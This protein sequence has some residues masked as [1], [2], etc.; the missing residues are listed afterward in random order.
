MNSVKT[1]LL[2]FFLL[3]GGALLGKYSSSFLSAEHLRGVE[4][5]VGLLTS[6]FGLLLSLQLSAGKTYFDHQEQD[7]TLMA[8]RVLLLDNV[9]ARYGPEAREAREMLRD[10]V[11]AFL[12]RVW[13]TEPSATSTWTPT[14]GITV[15]DKIEELS[16]QDE[17][18]RSKRTLALGMAI[19]LQQ[20]RWQT[21]VSVRSS[22]AVP[23]MIVETVWAT[24]IF[25]SFGLL[26]PHGLKAI[27]SLAVFASAVSSGFFMIE[28][29]NRPF[30]GVL[31]VSSFPI[32]EVIKHLAQEAKPSS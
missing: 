25:V 5:G 11:A 21:A 12:T 28:E 7:V 6:M 1:S 32:R 10:R 20:T 19:E 18:K 22:T 24:I 30:S 29:M 27:I 17:D 31:K 26:A 15:F 8:S 16:P 9:L 3:F 4:L 23:L 14:D 2:V 13:P